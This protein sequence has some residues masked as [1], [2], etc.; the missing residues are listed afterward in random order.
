[1]SKKFGNWVIGHG[2]QNQTQE[3][4]RGQ[5]YFLKITWLMA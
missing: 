5:K 4:R 3:I 2:G 1:M